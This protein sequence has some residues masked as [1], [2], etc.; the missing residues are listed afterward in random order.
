METI[1]NGENFDVI[2]WRKERVGS[3]FIKKWPKP[4]IEIIKN[5]VEKWDDGTSSKTNLDPMTFTSWGMVNGGRKV[6]CWETLGG[7]KVASEWRYKSGT[8]LKVKD[9]VPLK[10]WVIDASGQKG[11]KRK[12]FYETMHNHKMA[13]KC[14]E[15]WKHSTN[16]A[17]YKRF[18]SVFFVIRMVPTLKNDDDMGIRFGC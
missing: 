18:L 16:M 13:T 17:T 9:L 4:K 11:V 14:N 8:K 7:M 1:A 2:A 12:Y 15:N 3:C 5:G 10:N 6:V